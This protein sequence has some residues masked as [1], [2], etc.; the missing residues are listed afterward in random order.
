MPEAMFETMAPSIGSCRMDFGVAQFLFGRDVVSEL[1]AELLRDEDLEEKYQY[2]GRDR[3][4]PFQRSEF[5]LES[6]SWMR[7]LAA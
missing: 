5:V 7:S 3:R 2:N 1:G 4:N 6:N